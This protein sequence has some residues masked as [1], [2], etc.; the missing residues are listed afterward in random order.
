MIRI[1]WLFIA[2]LLIPLCLMP[3][4]VQAQPPL[5]CYDYVETFLVE[6]MSF[7]AENLTPVGHLS[8]S[9]RAIAEK[10]NY[11]YAGMNRELAVIDATDPNQLVRTGFVLMPENI[12][13]IAV[14]GNYAYV[15][16]YNHELRVVDISDPQAPAMV[17][18]CD[19]LGGAE[20][21][22][23]AVVG[24]Y[25]YAVGFRS[26]LYVIN[27]TEAS[28]PVIVAHLEP[29]DWSEYSSELIVAAPYLYIGDSQSGLQIVD[30]SDPTDPRRVALYHAPGDDI[31]DL[32]LQGN[33]L[34]VANGIKGLRV[35]DLSTPAAPQE[36]GRYWPLGV[37]NRINLSGDLALIQM[38]DN[39]QWQGVDVSNPAQPRRVGPMDL[40]KGAWDILVVEKRVYAFGSYGR[41]DSLTLIDI[42]VPDAPQTRGR[43]GK[44]FDISQ[45]VYASGHLFAIWSAGQR[46]SVFDVS[47]PVSPHWL[48]DYPFT[49]SSFTAI[50][51]ILYMGGAGLSLIDVSDVMTPVQIGYF[52]PDTHDVY[53]WLENVVVDLPYAYVTNRG[54]LYIVD[55]SNPADPRE[56]AHLAM[57][58]LFRPALAL[59]GDHLIIAAAASVYVVD[60]S[61]IT[62][63]ALVATVTGTGYVTDVATTDQH[64]YVLWKY[65]DQSPSQG[66]SIFDL[67]DPTQPVEVGII[68]TRFDIRSI[69]LDD[70]FLYIAWGESG[71]GGVRVLDIAHP[72]LPVEVA[73]YSRLL[74]WVGQLAVDGGTLYVPDLDLVVLEQ[75][76]TVR[77]R[78]LY[79]PT[80]KS[81]R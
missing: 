20:F 72:T 39:A 81:E 73:H 34:Y 5:E 64:A 14:E 23:V 59:M 27:V 75:D 44:P 4:S 76:R 42:S 56:V 1:V 63:P 22:H 50:D 16:L 43:Y 66:I 18:S 12:Q 58:Y 70:S 47:D 15:A 6:G 60:I 38:E 65:R 3:R 13:D 61:T 28:A 80:V 45:A 29:P 11:L 54:H 19:L 26:S 21:S 2:F 24:N 77:G 46:L 78:W 33:L 68:E 32:V 40:F 8:H 36:I 35:L 51:E 9:V 49:G 52:H 69:T 17:G 48:I 74:G 79:L 30:I 57:P 7:D 37:V 53:G 10:D 62:A 67:A 25:V 41:D 55:V 71:Y 31:R